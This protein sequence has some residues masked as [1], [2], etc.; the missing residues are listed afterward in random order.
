MPE[1]PEVRVVAKSLRAKILNKKIVDIQILRDKFIKEVP[2]SHF[3]SKIIGSS[4]KNVENVGKFLVFH[5]SNNYVFL[6][7]LRMEGKYSYYEYNEPIYRHNY[8]I[9]QFEDN[10][11]LRYSDSRMFGTFHL[12]TEDNYLKILPLSKLAKIPAEIDL[13]NLFAI[14]SKRKSKIKTL[15]LD[16]TLVLGLG[17]IYVN[18]ALWAAQIDPQRLGQ[19]ITKRELKSI[20]D[21]ATRIMDASTELGGT[22]I[23]SYESLNK[24]E[25]QFQ[26]FLQVHGRNKK[27]CKRC[28]EILDKIKVNGRGTYY[29]KKCQI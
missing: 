27:S 10:S 13:D 4:I 6:S 29:C 11:Q 28:Y 20:L 8:L 5:L 16:Q 26:N 21:H 24:K 23:S 3:C 1:L 2:A 14:I 18:E 12:R 7:H 17:N 15:L 19:N 22:T 9:F 25:G